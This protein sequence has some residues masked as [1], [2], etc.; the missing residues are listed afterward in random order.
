M[1]FDETENKLSTPPS[2][3]AQDQV[4]ETRTGGELT[5]GADNVQNRP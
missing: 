2:R 1:C 4:V 3:P 5:V